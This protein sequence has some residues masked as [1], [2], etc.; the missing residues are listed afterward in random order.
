MESISSI[1]RDLSPEEM[2]IMQKVSCLHIRLYSRSWGKSEAGMKSCHF[3]PKE[4]EM[5]RETSQWEREEMEKV[6]SE[7]TNAGF[8]QACHRGH[9]FRTT[10]LAFPNS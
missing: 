4:V 10:A 6:V 3:L 9:G 1:D 8:P 2:D 5:V 7:L